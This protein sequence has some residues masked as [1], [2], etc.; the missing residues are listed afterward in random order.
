[1][2]ERDAAETFIWRCES[3]WRNGAHDIDA[4][5][6]AD[7]ILRGYRSVKFAGA[8]GELL[9]GIVAQGYSDLSIEMA[10]SPVTDAA[11]LLACHRP[12]PAPDRGQ[13]NLRHAASGGV[14]RQIAAVG[15]LE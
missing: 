6:M 2:P 11:I 14:R 15:H 10:P 13:A 8:I 1:M 5:Y 4:V 9:N 7:A 12:G 3:F